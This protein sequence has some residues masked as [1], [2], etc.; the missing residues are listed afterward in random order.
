[1]TDQQG[2]RQTIADVPVGEVKV[3]VAQWPSM[4]IWDVGGQPKRV[5]VLRQKIHLRT[6]IIRSHV[7]RR[8][9][10]L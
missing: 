10:G 1:M 4:R 6:S 2:C 3:Q 7:R 8:V 9:W 5:V